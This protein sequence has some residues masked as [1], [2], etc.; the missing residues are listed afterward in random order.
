MKMEL[1]R[2]QAFDRLGQTAAKLSEQAAFHLSQILE[3][4]GIQQAVLT[5]A[6]GMSGPVLM[7]PDV[8]FFDGVPPELSKWAATTLRGIAEFMYAFGMSG[9]T[10]KPENE[11]DF[12]AL[13]IAW[14]SMTSTVGSDQP[15]MKGWGVMGQERIS[16]PT[17]MA[18][19]IPDPEPE[20][21]DGDPVEDPAYEAA[22]EPEHSDDSNGPD[23]S[24][25]VLTL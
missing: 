3:T 8:T 1:T 24:E 18:Y 17:G 19:P 21:P 16:V 23:D 11:Q 13:R 22:T 10:V 4:L 7:V 12:A 15:L 9:I 25:E 2:T 5:V 14:T 6:P 20:I